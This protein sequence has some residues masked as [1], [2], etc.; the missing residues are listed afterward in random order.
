MA[1]REPGV[2]RDTAAHNGMSGVPGRRRRGVV[3]GLMAVVF[4]LYRKLMAEYSVIF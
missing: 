4:I 2:D 3:K 1:V